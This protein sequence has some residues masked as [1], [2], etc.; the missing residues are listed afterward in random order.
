MLTVA[1][2]C[3][4]VILLVIVGMAVGVMNG[5]DPLK[6]TC[7]GLNRI[8]LRDG[9]CPVCGDDP[10]KCDGDGGRSAETG[11]RRAASLGRDALR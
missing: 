10:A 5:R 6:G 11:D 9:E 4:A 7:G 3:F 1:L 2:I 8:G